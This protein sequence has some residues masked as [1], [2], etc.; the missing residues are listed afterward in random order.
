MTAWSTIR[1]VLSL[2]LVTACDVA[3]IRPPVTIDL[4]GTDGVVCHIRPAADR[5]PTVCASLGID[6]AAL[7]VDGDRN[8]VID[9]V[10]RRGSVMYVVSVAASRIVDELA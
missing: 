8:V 1:F 5:N 6:V 4:G 7:E 2:V 10:V 9:A 3:D